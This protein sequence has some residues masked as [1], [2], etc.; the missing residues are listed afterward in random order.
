VVDLDTWIRQAVDRYKSYPKVQ[1]DSIRFFRDPVR[2]I[3]IDRES[4]LSPA[5]GVI[6]YVK[7]VE[8]QNTALVEVKGRKFT[9][10]DLLGGRFCG[11]CYV[12]GIFMTFY[13]VH[14]NRVPLGGYLKYRRLPCLYT[15][16][17]PMVWFEKALINKNIEHDKM[18]YV[19]V[20]ERV[21]N[22]FTVPSIPYTYYVI[23]IA[24]SEVDIVA[25]FKDREVAGVQ[26][27]KRFSV[28]RWGSQVDV[29]L[30]KSEEVEITPKVKEMYHVRGGVDVL[31]SIRERKI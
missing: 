21:I 8:D 11:P 29:V 5:D 31:F 25:L 13:D 14:V 7:D 15:N 12:V 20:N 17:L 26:Q 24:D 10:P 1:L 19:F 27:G 6:L 16:N 22:E 2:P 28:V 4:F 30:P 23:Q 9:V 18:E 3:L